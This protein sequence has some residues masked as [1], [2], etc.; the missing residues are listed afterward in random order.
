MGQDS[1]QKSGLRTINAAPTHPPK[2]MINDGWSS[3]C[4]W[5]MVHARRRTSED[6]AQ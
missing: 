1:I 5:R 2:L 4:D 6:T 3:T